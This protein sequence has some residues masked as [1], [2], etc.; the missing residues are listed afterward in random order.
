MIRVEDITIKRGVRHIVQNFTWEI[1]NNEYW[2]LFGLNGCGKTT[3]LQAMAGYLGVN[4]GQIIVNNNRLTKE[5]KFDWRMR[6]G[7]VSAS[8][9]SQ[10]YHTEPVLEIILSSLT[11]R[12]GV[13]NEVSA[14]DVVN[15]KNLLRVLGLDKKHQ[16]PFNT[17]SSGQ[18]QKVLLARALIHNPDLLILDEPF[19]GLDILGRMQVQEL[20]NEWMKQDGH[21]LV[22]VTHH[23]DEITSLYTHGAL[24]KDGKLFAAGAIQ[25]VFTTDSINQF[26]GREAEVSWANGRLG[27]DIPS[28]R[29][30][31]THNG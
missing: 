12:L 23:C 18:Q 28:N 29:Y 4:K 9:F 15:A 10:C 19:N 3:L 5:N 31:G 27:I 6:C 30:G 7:F 26:L 24:M 11:G 8:F 20:L 1:K 22:T 17:L 25:E 16:Y 13:R 21:S 14:A 2:L